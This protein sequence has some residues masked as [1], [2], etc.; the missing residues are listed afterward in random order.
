MTIMACLRWREQRKR[1]Q[2]ADKAPPEVLFRTLVEPASEPRYPDEISKAYKVGGLG[3]MRS[4]L[5]Q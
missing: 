2:N 4:G 5:A 1:D 3:Y